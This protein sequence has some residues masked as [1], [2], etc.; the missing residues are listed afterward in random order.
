MDNV[1]LVEPHSTTKRERER[2]LGKGCWWLRSVVLVGNELLRVMP[3][4]ANSLHHT[5]SLVPAHQLL[6]N[7]LS[8]LPA[9]GEMDVM[10][11]LVSVFLMLLFMQVKYAV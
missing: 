11:H 7:S 5:V 3:V 4:T 10:E 9:K 8:H 6:S 2:G 1:L